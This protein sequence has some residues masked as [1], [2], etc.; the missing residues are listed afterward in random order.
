MTANLSAAA[1]FAAAQYDLRQD[2]DCRADILL[3]TTAEPEAAFLGEQLA[4]IDPWARLGATAGQLSA[5]LS[6]STGDKRC[7][8]I[9]ADGAPAGAISVRFPWLSGPYLNLL[10]IL[11]AYRRIGIGKAALNWM[12]TQA[13][14]ADARNCWLCVSA[15]NGAAMA[16]YRRRGYMEAATLEGLIKDEEDEILM[17]KRLG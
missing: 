11:P 9:F 12:E 3:A 16:F 15:F 10:A 6:L 7:Y 14:M 1:P 2:T 13:V 5:F 17:R 4:R 8:T